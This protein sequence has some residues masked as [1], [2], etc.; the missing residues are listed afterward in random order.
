MNPET[1]G[2]PISR[3]RQT[4]SRVLLIQ[5]NGCAESAE[6]V[7]VEIQRSL[8]SGTAVRTTEAVAQVEIRDLDELATKGEMLESI[9][10]QGVRVVSLRKT[11]SGT[12]SAVVDRP[13]R[14]ARRHCDTERL[15]IGLT[16]ASTD[17]GLGMNFLAI[18]TIIILNNADAQ[19]IVFFYFWSLSW[20]GQK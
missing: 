8:D 20:L 4:K 15:K 6:V 9:S 12:Q 18:V 19:P 11:H 17:G 1:T 10:G 7:R 2:N 5:I 3:M 14:E 16:L 13:T